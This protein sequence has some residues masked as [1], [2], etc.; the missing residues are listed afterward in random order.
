MQMGDFHEEKGH[1]SEAL[2]YFKRAFSEEMTIFTTSRLLRCTLSAGD[3]EQ[4]QKYID[5]ALRQGYD[6]GSYIIAFHIRQGNVKIALREA[7][8]IIQSGKEI[9]DIPK[10]TTRRLFA[11]ISFL[12][13]TGDMPEEDR[14]EITIFGSHLL[15]CTDYD[16]PLPDMTKILDHWQYVTALCD[17]YEGDM[18]HEKIRQL[19]EPLLK[20]SDLHPYAS[21]L[22]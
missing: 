17:T 18:L 9:V 7:L 22:S 3:F 14:D 2:Y 15:A 16:S 21:V 5:F 19:I 20:T 13:N 12:L 8:R 6:I 4:A 1:Y 10:G 11:A